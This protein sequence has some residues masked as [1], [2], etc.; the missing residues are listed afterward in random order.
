MPKIQLGRS[1]SLL[2]ALITIPAV[3]SAAST[4]SAAGP[5]AT[6]KTLSD[7]L[8]GGWY[9]RINV[10]GFGVFQEPVESGL[11]PGNTLNIP[12]YQAEL[13]IRP[14]LNLNVR[15]VELSAKP[16]FQFLWQ[17][18][19][20][21]SR[22]GDDDTSV[23]FF[24]NEWFARFRLADELFASYGRENLQWG[25]SALLSPSNPFN[26]DNGRNNPKVEVPGLDYGRVIWLPSSAWTLSFIANTD[27]GR[28]RPLVEFQRSYA[29][30]ADYTGTGKYVSFI[31]SQR[32]ENGFSLGMFGGWNATDALLLYA[33]GSGSNQRATAA[34]REDYEVLV[35]G[36]YTLE[37]GGTITLEY[38][39][40]N[41]GCDSDLIDLC[42]LTSEVDPDDLISE[43]DPDDILFRRNYLMLQY[44]D[45][46]VWRD[47]NL[48]LRMI[49]DIDD[50]SNRAIGIFEYEVGDHAQVYL[51]ANAFTGDRDTEFGSLLDYSVFTGVAYTF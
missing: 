11:N 2:M 30:K 35:G 9:S 28:F 4:G 25:P 27:E 5:S 37:G 40:N 12:S 34:D 8:W 20:E 43:I 49:Q 21:G 13:D 42:L 32:E 18:W 31:A 45:T 15:R 50:G 24:F 44:N 3:A 10:L 1:C 48:S 14:D 33:E 51:I 29:L 19:Q 36:A 26:K 47:L 16:R 17:K 39:Y 38:F 46:K 7:E 22:A 23:Q 6:E 41:D